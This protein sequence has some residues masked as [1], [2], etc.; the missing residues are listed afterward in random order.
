[1]ALL[2]CSCDGPE[3]AYEKPLEG[4]DACRAKGGTCGDGCT[5]PDSYSAVCYLPFTPAEDEYS[6]DGRIA[7]KKTEVCVYSYGFGDSCSYLFCQLPP[8]ACENDMSC[9]C[10]LQ[11][12]EDYMP[13]FEAYYQITCEV[14]PGGLF[15]SADAGGAVLWQSPPP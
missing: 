5:G 11:A 1:M 2:V 15:V 3:K 9:E 6:C 8:E 4:C 14:V 10:L 12:A 13:G 7:C